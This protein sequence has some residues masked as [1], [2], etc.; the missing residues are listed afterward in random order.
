MNLSKG[1]LVACLWMQS[2]CIQLQRVISL[3]CKGLNPVGTR[4]RYKFHISMGPSLLS[5]LEIVWMLLF[6]QPQRDC[7][8]YW[9]ARV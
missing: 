8:L 3:V 1:Q 6:Q 7:S 5:F 2:E 9:I 4:E